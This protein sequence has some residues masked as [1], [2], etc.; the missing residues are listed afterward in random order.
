MSA[1]APAERLQS[2]DQF[3]GYTC[4]GMFLVNF[5]GGYQVMPQVLK[6]T[7]DYCS[8]ADTIMP[9]F[10]FAAG[11][12]LRLSYLK[13]LEHGGGSEAWWRMI[14]R[15]FSLALVAIVWYSLGDWGGI[16]KTIEEKGLVATLAMCA[17]RNWL[18]TLLHIAVTSLFILPVLWAP[19]GIR[20]LYGAAA[21]IAHVWLSWKFNFLW[22]Q[23]ITDN[24]N[25]ITR[26][27]SGIDGGPLGF[28]TWSIVAL[29]GTWACDVVRAARKSA[30]P[31]QPANY[32]TALLKL[33]VAGWLLAA[34][35]WVISCG[36]TIY[37]VKP[38]SSLTEDQIYER[39]KQKFPPNPVIPSQEQL[40][41]WDRKPAEPPFVPPPP[42]SQRKWNY[43]MMSQR[44]GTLSY[45]TFSA[46]FSLLIYA[47]FL[48]LADVKGIRIGLFRTLGVNALA[49]Y[50]LADFTGTFVKHSL[51]TPKDASMLYASTAF[52]IHLLL[53]YIALRVMEKGKIYWRM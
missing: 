28:L 34:F 9:G 5:V 33:L 2:L 7:H 46:G 47:I 36:T 11:F 49:G 13:H 17:K 26:G 41:A 44:A 25:D 50:I 31:D 51:A 35:G 29:S 1:A 53:I 10:L 42:I 22:T 6:H 30:A 38:D 37:D 24:V 27:V 15:C 40:A 3:R 43:W 39:A 4:A 48:W 18:Q 52:A 12:A 8:Y 19:I 14:R 32:Q 20:L 21:G 23:G 16:Q 45:L